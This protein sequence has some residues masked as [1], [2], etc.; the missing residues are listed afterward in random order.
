[1]L[2]TVAT[3]V[4]RGCADWL[5]ER[6]RFSKTGSIWQKWHSADTTVMQCSGNCRLLRDALGDIQRA[7]PVFDEWENFAVT[8]S[9]GNY[10]WIVLRF[11][12]V[13][14]LIKWNAFVV[15]CVPWMDAAAN[16]L[17]T[18]LRCGMIYFGGFNTS[19]CSDVGLFAVQTTW[20]QAGSRATR[21]L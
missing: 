2:G 9:T 18:D 12:Y 13:Y 5:E 11:L 21:S 19:G 1:M 4:E 10:M 17:R 8:L 7:N 6:T 16:C 14:R 15:V 20:Q 3:A